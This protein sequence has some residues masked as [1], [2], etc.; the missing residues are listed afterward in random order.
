MCSIVI[1][2]QCLYALGENRMEGECMHVT[3]DERA[4]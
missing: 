1:R 2:L 4:R 3:I